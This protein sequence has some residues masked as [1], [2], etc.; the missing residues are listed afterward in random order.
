MNEE[1]FTEMSN[2]GA[3]GPC[4]D[5][6]LSKDSLSEPFIKIRRPLALRH[7]S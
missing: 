6:T 3:S 5:N 4:R 1:R 2:P 7:K